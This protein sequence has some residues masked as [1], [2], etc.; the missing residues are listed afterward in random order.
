M[1][2]AIDNGFTTLADAV[3]AAELLP[4]LTDPFSTFTV[5]A[6]TNDAF[7]ALGTTVS[8]L[9]QDPTGDLQD[10]LLYHVLEAEVEA[11]AVMNGMIADAVSTTNTLKADQDGRWRRIRQSGRGD[12]G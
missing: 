3:I 11:A 8:D 7:D 9:L 1:D 4:V 2:V 5:F 10:I 6:P 12:H